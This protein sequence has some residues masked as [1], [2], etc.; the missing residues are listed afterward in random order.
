VCVCVCVC[1]WA[2]QSVGG[3][4]KHLRPAE[5]LHSQLYSHFIQEIESRADSWEFLSFENGRT[6]YVQ[7]NIL[8]HNAKDVS[9]CRSLSAEE[10]LFIGLFCGRWPQKIRHPI[11]IL[12]KLRYRVA[13]MQVSFRKRAT[14]YRAL[15]RNMTYRDKASYVQVGEAS[16]QGGEDE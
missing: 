14:H 6:N 13:K 10:P 1:S 2:C 12:A 9:N 15:L 7:V 8:N 5:F 11:Y 16:L 4:W 3:R